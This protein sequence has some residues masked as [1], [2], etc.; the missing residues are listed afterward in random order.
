MSH[1]TWGL[2]LVIM[3]GINEPG[4]AS[5]SSQGKQDDSSNSRQ[6]NWHSLWIYCLTHSNFVG[7]HK[8][9]CFW[10]DMFTTPRDSCS[11]EPRLLPFSLFSTSESFQEAQIVAFPSNQNFTS[12][13]T[14]WQLWIT[15]RKPGKI[16][17]LINSCCRPWLRHRI[18]ATPLQDNKDFNSQDFK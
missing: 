12:L 11:L 18:L 2:T 7:K 13:G 16:Q 9:A 1:D 6:E 14:W 17:V 15:K 4:F 10:C 5:S 3:L 8:Y